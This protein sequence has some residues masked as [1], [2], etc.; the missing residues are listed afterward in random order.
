MY[1]III[2]KEARVQRGQ[3]KMY[4]LKNQTKIL[5]AGNGIR[6]TKRVL[7]LDPLKLLCPAV[8]CSSLKGGRAMITETLEAKTYKQ[9][10]RVELV[11]DV[12]DD[13]GRVVAERGEIVEV[14]LDADLT[15]ESHVIVKNQRGMLG[16]AE[17]CDIADS[18]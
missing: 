13:Y 16:V 15:N 5:K 7:L 11:N 2:V 3:G 14:W 9:G 10:Q 8:A 18:I 4:N 6:P 12:I 1:A 17:P